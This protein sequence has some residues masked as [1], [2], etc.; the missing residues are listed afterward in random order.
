MSFTPPQMLQRNP[1]GQGS[2]SFTAD[3]SW[4]GVINKIQ[5]ASGAQADVYLPSVAAMTGPTFVGIYPCWDGGIT[6]IHPNGNDTICGNPGPWYMM[7]DENFGFVS[8]FPLMTPQSLGSGDSTNWSLPSR[9]PH[10][11][12][13]F[14]GH[15]LTAQPQMSPTGD[16]WVAVPGFTAALRFPCQSPSSRIKVSVSVSVSSTNALDRMAFSLNVPNFG[17]VTPPFVAPAQPG[18]EGLDSSRTPYT[19]D[20]MQFN[21]FWSQPFGSG[22]LTDL[23]L[24]QHPAQLLVKNSDPGGTLIFNPAMTTSSMEIEEFSVA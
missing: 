22:F 18:C 9:S 23:R 20:S 16:Q 12:Q 24:D 5:L 7:Q 6:V 10:L 13:G 3:P 4:Y 15:A 8:D 17:L 21:F 19:S 2:S 14:I 11:R 1:Y